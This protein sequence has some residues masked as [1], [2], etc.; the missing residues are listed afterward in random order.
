M[1]LHPNWT[2]I[3]GLNSLRY[4]EESVLL[5]NAQI[6]SGY[7][8]ITVKTGGATIQGTL[9]SQDNEK[10]VV[11]V[12]DAAG[13]EEERTILLSELDPEPIEELTDLT[14]KGYFWI[15]V[16]LADTGV[17]V[18]GDLVEEDD[19]K[20]YTSGGWRPPNSFQVECK[21]SSD[22]D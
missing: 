1:S 21:G 16:T 9:V 14:G 22:V 11:R 5:P 10:I 20:H 13:N 19:E 3:A 6:V 15:Q 7:G 4:I 2:D 18:S 12:K 8:S 17:T